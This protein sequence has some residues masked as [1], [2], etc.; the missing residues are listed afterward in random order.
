[1]KRKYAKADDQ[2]FLDRISEGTLWVDLETQQVYTKKNRQ[3]FGK[4]HLVSVRPDKQGYL[5]VRIY[6]LKKR[7]S[8]AL[9]RL[10]WIVANGRLI[11]DDMDIDHYP[12]RSITNNHP[13]NLRLRDKIEN[14]MDNGRYDTE[15]ED[16]F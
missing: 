13:D 10:I 3:N 16:D 4:W 1:M 11:P 14:R 6:H 9:S 15:E 12:D 5:H 2:I 7:K 8:I